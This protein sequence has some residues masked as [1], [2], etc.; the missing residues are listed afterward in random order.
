MS[1]KSKALSLLLAAVLIAALPAPV[2]AAPPETVSPQ[3]EWINIKTAPGSS[4]SSPLD[5]YFTSYDY[6]TTKKSAL[7]DSTGRM[8][9]GYELDFAPHIC[10]GG[11]SVILERNGVYQFC[12]TNNMEV[13][14]TADV[15]SEVFGEFFDLPSRLMVNRSEIKYLYDM[16][17]NCLTEG[18]IAMSNYFAVK[19]QGYFVAK[20]TDGDFYLV[21]MDGAVQSQGYASMWPISGGCLTVKNHAGEYGVIDVSEN[22]VTP[23]IPHLILDCPEGGGKLII[24][25]TGR[26]WGLMERDGTVLIP[27]GSLPYNIDNTCT[28]NAKL[29]LMRVNAAD[30]SG[31]G[32]I[33][34]TGKVVIPFDFYSVESSTRESNL[35]ESGGHVA[36][37]F[38]IADHRPSGQDRVYNGQ[39]TL[40]LSADLVTPVSDGSGFIAQ[41]G[42]TGALYSPDGRQLFSVNGTLEEVAPGYYS[43][44][45]QVLEPYTNLYGLCD[46]TGKMI[47][48][49]MDCDLGFRCADPDDAGNGFIMS[50]YKEN[51][52]KDAYYRA[53]GRQLIPP[54]YGY[55]N[56]RPDGYFL[57]SDN[58]RTGILRYQT[59]GSAAPVQ[60]APPVEP[61]DPGMVNFIDRAAYAPG[62]FYDVAGSAWYSPAVAGAVEL[63]L[64]NGKGGGVFDPGGSVTLAEAVKMAAMVHSIYSGLGGA[65]T[66]GTPWYQVYVDYATENGILPAGGFPDYNAKATRA[67]MAGVFARAMPETELAAINSV[68]ALPDVDAATPYSEEI[69]RLYRAGVLTGSDSQGS[70]TPADP[71]SRA[72]A[73]AIILRV[74]KPDSR[75]TLAF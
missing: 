68:D 2:A 25:G 4:L 13:L 52:Q 12:R 10:Q 54:I 70:F 5:G 66:Q 48:P 19:G 33:D 17:G 44:Y 21:D 36:F 59:A 49:M 34:K 71:I 35:P 16:D 22:I 46:S 11:G 72:E 1:R 58:E 9:I 14:I 55:I 62:Q 75:Q 53:D 50:T 47:I 51:G 40:L 31:M 20:A 41:N 18:Y 73:A 24:S 56:Y 27:V 29:G 65:F 42:N 23:F 38:A 45:R 60:P 43:I 57:V 69:F 67:E 28:Y 26:E 15:I 37:T 3:V 8:L 7:F 64:M 30:Y 61:T 32:M 74:A 6:T 39:G 63:G